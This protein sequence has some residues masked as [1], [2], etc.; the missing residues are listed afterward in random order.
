M[1]EEFIHDLKNKLSSK[2]YRSRKRLNEVD[3]VASVCRVCIDK[4]SSAELSEAINSM[5]QWYKNSSV[6]Y[7]YLADISRKNM[8]LA[9]SR[10][11][12]RGWTLQELIAPREV[13]FFDED[14]REI[15]HRREHAL[16]ISRIT[17]IDPNL[18]PR[19]NL[20]KTPQADFVS[21][22]ECHGFLNAR[23]PE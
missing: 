8:E 16:L 17:G 2:D 21:Q 18:L 7:V 9:S 15:G 1:E 6:C 19:A 10:W 23:L 11:F 12:T 14:W 20:F 13:V 5:F 22:S 3:V 4:S